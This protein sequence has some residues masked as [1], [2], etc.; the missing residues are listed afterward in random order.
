L[1]LTYAL[2]FLLATDPFAFGVRQ[3][4]DQRAV[5]L[6]FSVFGASALIPGFGI[7]LMRPLG[8]IQSAISPTQ[9]ERIGPYIVAGIFYLWLF[10]NLYGSGQTP[11]L[12]VKFVLGATIGLFVAFFINIFT[13][14]SAHAVGMGSLTG[15]IA[16]ALWQWPGHL[17]EVPAGGGILEISHNAVLASAVILAGLVGTA[18]L[19]LGA[20]TPSG[21]YRGYI[22]GFLTTLLANWLI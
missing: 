10:R 9:Q 21:L 8:F 7:A 3:L 17:L 13:R 15:M 1:V 4:T 11:P 14:I 5:L 19:A 6:L 18:R 20:H 2:L 16:L 12:Y 22:V